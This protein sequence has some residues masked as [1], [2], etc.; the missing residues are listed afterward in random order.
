[1]PREDEKTQLINL[2]DSVLLLKQNA[3]QILAVVKESFTSYDFDGRPIQEDCDRMQSNGE[4][5]ECLWSGAFNLLATEERTAS[6]EV[7]LALKKVRNI[8]Y[9]RSPS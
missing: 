6:S 1:M 8:S 9:C 7:S 5:L 3:E 2:E 4:L